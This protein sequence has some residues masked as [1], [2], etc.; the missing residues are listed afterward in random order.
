MLLGKD[1]TTKNIT[2]NIPLSAFM[3]V[4]QTVKQTNYEPP[5]S[6]RESAPLPM[7]PL[8]GGH[9]VHSVAPVASAKNPAGQAVQSSKPVSEAYPTGQKSEC[10]NIQL[11]ILNTIDGWR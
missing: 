4:Y 3:R 11:S 5:Q 1:Y 6:S 7:V 9:F 8:P 2:F 10:D